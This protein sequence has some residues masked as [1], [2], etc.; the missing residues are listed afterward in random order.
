MKQVAIVIAEHIVKIVDL[1]II[2]IPHMTPSK[3]LADSRKFYYR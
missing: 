3:E 1:G 2:L